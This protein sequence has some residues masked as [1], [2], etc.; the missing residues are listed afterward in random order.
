MEVVPC[1][2]PFREP[3]SNMLW[4]IEIQH[5]NDDRDVMTPEEIK[6]RGWTC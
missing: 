3:K 2:E 4:L 1:L 5:R 6:E